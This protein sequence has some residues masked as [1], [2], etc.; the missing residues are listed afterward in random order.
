MKKRLLLMT[1]LMCTMTAWAQTPTPSTELEPYITTLSNKMVYK[2]NY[3]STSVTGEPVVLS[4]LLACWAPKEPD[5]GV[6]I[7]SVHIYSHYTITANSQ[8]PTNYTPSSADFA[9]LNSLFEGG[10]YDEKK[11]YK[12]IVK[13]SVVIMPDYE[14]YGVSVN[15]THPYL[16]E[17]VTARQV[18]DALTYGLQLYAKLDGAN[19]TLPLADDWRCFS[20]GYSQGGA[21][22]LAVQRYIEENNLGDQLHFRGTICGDGPYDLLA[23][24]SYYIDDNGTSYDVNTIHREDQVTLPAVL[25]M[26]LNGMLASNPA[27]ASHTL[28]DYFSQSFLDTGIMDW[29]NSKN[30]SSDDINNAWLKQIDNGTV[31]IGTETYPAP[32]NMNEMFLK[33]EIP[34][35]IW[36]TTTVAWA[37]LDDVFTPGFYNY[38][39]NPDNFTNPAAMTGDA[40]EDM[41]CVLEANNVFTGWQPQHR[42]QFAHSKGDMIVPYGN[43]MAFS[44]AYPDDEGDTYRIDN[45]FSNSDHLNAGTAF[46]MKLG[47]DFFDYFEWID[48]GKPTGIVQVE[49]GKWKEEGGRWKEDSWYDLSGRKLQGKPTAKGLYIVNGRKKIVKRS[50]CDRE[51]RRHL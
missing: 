21:V 1:A 47:T 25:P 22:A 2:F 50:P 30:M 37:L 17:K 29:L 23:T 35:M 18:V 49:S 15:R 6:E 20:L 41:R 5:T 39:D 34:G 38:L 4:S 31:T 44:L 33:Q 27:M 40:Y 28:S 12:T 7:E 14:G 32:S 10:E 26:I 51:Q 45:T 48:D 42:I 9:V 13:R 11:P 43:Y 19:N 3:P 24:L 36:G 46:I 16:V 8:C